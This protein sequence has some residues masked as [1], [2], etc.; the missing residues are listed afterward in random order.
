[1]GMFKQTLAAHATAGPNH[2]YTMN[3][4]VIYHV[5]KVNILGVCS[6]LYYAACIVEFKKEE[7]T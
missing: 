7:F 2:E 3:Y 6:I 1:M 5:Q 4:Y